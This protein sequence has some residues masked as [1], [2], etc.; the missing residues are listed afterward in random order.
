MSSIAASCPQDVDCADRYLCQC[1]ADEHDR[2]KAVNRGSTEHSK[3]GE[4]VNL[5]QSVTRSL[6]VFARAMWADGQT[7]TYA[8]TEADRSLSACLSDRGRAWGRTGAP[9]PMSPPVGAAGAGEWV[10][11]RR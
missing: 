9:N 10:A 2:L 7:E 1:K 8:F 11:A 3:V 4:G 5:E 6:G